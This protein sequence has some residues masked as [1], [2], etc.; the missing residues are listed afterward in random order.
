M[1]LLHKRGRPFQTVQPL[2]MLDIELDANV[3][4]FD[5]L[6]PGEL[7]NCVLYVYAGVFVCSCIAI[8]CAGRL[9]PPADQEQATLMASLC[10]LT[11]L[12]VSTQVTRLCE[13][14]ALLFLSCS[15]HPHVCCTSSHFSLAQTTLLASHHSGAARVRSPR[16]EGQK[17]KLLVSHLLSAHLSKGNVFCW[18]GKHSLDHF[19]GV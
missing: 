17:K 6:I 3:Q 15:S 8:W 19:V 10:P 16:H 14:S 7:D 13:V 12:C 18:K 1:N 4:S 2:Q 5:H 9:T 11:R